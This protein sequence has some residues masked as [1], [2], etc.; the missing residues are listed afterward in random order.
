[1]P[2]TTAFGRDAA[3]RRLEH[4]SAASVR[5]AA[6]EV[7]VFLLSRWPEVRVAAV[8]ALAR[9]GVGAAALR[10]AAKH[11]RNEVV[12]AVLCESLLMLDDKRSVPILKRRAR[13]HPS[14]LVRRKA[15][16]AISEILEGDAV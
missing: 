1:M 10:S 9:G 14:A 2:K 15:V 3:F 12:L 8:E 6:D 7:L 13:D 16:W 11:E 4:M 5:D